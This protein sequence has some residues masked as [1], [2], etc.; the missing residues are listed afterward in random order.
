MQLLFNTTVATMN[1]L[2]RKGKVYDLP[3]CEAHKILGGALAEPYDAPD[4]CYV[5]IIVDDGISPL[6]DVMVKC[7]GQIAVI[8]HTGSNGQL[9]L[10]LPRGEYHIEASKKEYRTDKDTVQVATDMEIETTCLPKEV[11]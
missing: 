1:G 10:C 7:K 11:K 4:F 8:G 9:I 6:P 2:Y 3:D 5:Q